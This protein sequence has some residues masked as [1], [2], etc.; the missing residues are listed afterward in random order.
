[1]TILTPTVLLFFIVVMGV[2]LGKIKVYSISFDISGVLIIA[3][4][5]GILI[6]IIYPEIIDTNFEN[7]L[8]LFSKLGTALFTTSI[9][10]TAGISV[11]KGFSKR[12][13]IFF[14]IG[15]LMVCICFLF[16]R[17][18]Q[19][20]DTAID[21]SVLVGILCGSMTSTPGLT[22]ACEL[23]YI[24]IENSILGYGCTYLFGVLGI[25]VFVQIMTR[26]NVQ[27]DDSKTINNS[28]IQNQN[29]EHM[30]IVGVSVILGYIVAG[31]KIPYLNFSLGTSG[32]IL[33]S[34][35][36]I[37]I[38]LSK[39]TDKTLDLTYALSFYRNF[40]LM[41]FFVGSGITSG[42]ELNVSFQIKWFL[43]GVFL[44]FMPIAF[45]YMCSR[46]IF[47]QSVEKSLCIVAG[48]MTST[49][50]IGALL[51]KSRIN[52]DLSMYSFSYIGALLTMVIGI[53]IF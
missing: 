51:K 11:L 3:V 21:K 53:R 38:I 26:K 41:L 34:S 43:Y 52:L 45:G 10:L 1:M 20:I 23:T 42:I 17:I 40:G 4:L 24:T 15:V 2:F 49:P 27:K 13:F 12:N 25:V 36:L 48:G 35:I 47:K 44:T 7:S 9:G 29:S 50:A 19:H 32:G 31:V 6:S 46:Y 28:V 16:M 37:G 18:I 22:S 30:M 5:T 14:S 33:C 8:S 39:V